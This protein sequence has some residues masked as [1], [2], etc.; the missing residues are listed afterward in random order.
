MRLKDKSIVVTGAS[1][2][3]GKAI[4][5]RF[6][7]EGAFVVAV[8]RRK[9]RLD[10]LKESLAQEKGQ[11][12]VFQGD[13]SKK[14]DNEK[15]IELAVQH[16]GKLDVLVNNAGIMDDMSGIGDA[17]DEK[18]EQVMKVNVYGPMCAMRKA[19]S[20]FKEQGHGNIINVASVGG[21][22]TV[23]GA[24]YCASKAALLAM[25]RNTAFMYIPDHIRCNAIAPGG[26]QTEIANSMGMPNPNG[27]ARVQK[28][29]AA[30]PQPG[31]PEDIAAAAL[32]LASD[33]SQYIN[34]DALVVDGGW[35][36]G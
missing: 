8:A 31:A 23:A 7:K 27:Y 9:E 22:R 34:G 25:T 15:M 6:V 36:A 18:Y 10:A 33:E 2:G 26:I 1:S 19:V 32:F 29:L 24:I 14:E 21:M 5:E 4:V 12:L 3:M 11:V 35:I 16:F 17:T 28:V 30:A 20:V 13:V